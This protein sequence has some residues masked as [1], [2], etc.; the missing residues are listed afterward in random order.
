MST[1]G[2]IALL[3]LTAATLRL[4]AAAS[5]IAN[6]RSTGPLSDAANAS[7]YAPAYTPVEVTQTPNAAGG[8][9]ATLGPSTR[10]AI[11]AYDPN[12]PYANAQGL[13]ASLDV[14]LTEQ[15]VGLIT[16][17]YAFTA[18]L[19]TMQAEAE[20]LATALSITA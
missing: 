6:M 11:A 2:A 18:N 14:D 9:L 19:K 1:V 4:E 16:S 13:V 20:M 17:G 3:G 12:A 8:V 15:V 5:S 10:E 7:S